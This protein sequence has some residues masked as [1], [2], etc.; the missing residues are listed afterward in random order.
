MARNVQKAGQRRSKRH[1]LKKPAA[2]SKGKT[3]SDRL[4][5]YL[6]T[7][8]PGGRFKC[9]PAGASP[10]TLKRLTCGDG[11]QKSVREGPLLR[12]LKK[13]PPGPWEPLA[14]PELWYRGCLPDWI[15]LPGERGPG[16]YSPSLKNDALFWGNNDPCIVPYLPPPSKQRG[17][18]SV[19]ICP[20]GNYMF[21]QPFEAAPVA[22]YFAGKLGIPAF[23][24]KYRLLPDAG[25]EESLADVRAGVREARRHAPRGPLAI[26][27]FSAGGHLV[28]SASA[29]SAAWWRGERPDAQVLVY[30]CINGHDWIDEAKCGFGPDISLDTPQVRSLVKHQP[31]IIPGPKFVPPPPTFM[32]GSTA[33]PECAPSAHSDLYAQAVMTA[34]VPL[35]Y[36]RDDFGGHGFGLKEFWAT[37]CL[38]WLQSRKFGRHSDRHVPWQDL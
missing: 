18:G 6:T 30:P 27:G 13:P 29:R 35:V 4:L 28:A 21:L 23:V 14:E 19:L 37:A 3:S 22:K 5:T 16:L 24:L 26:I 8:P 38:R 15:L 7:V 17:R 1:V 12:L 34:D 2:K 31:L 20:G 11:S 33:D 32:V 25:L 36:M 10:A 9:L